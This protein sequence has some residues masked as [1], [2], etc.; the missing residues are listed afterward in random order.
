[1][2]APPQWILLAF[3]AGFASND[4]LRLAQNRLAGWR[5]DR[6]LRRSRERFAAC[7][8]Q[9]VQRINVGS[10]EYPVWN[11]KCADCCAL[12]VDTFVARPDDPM[13]AQPHH[14]TPNIGRPTPGVVIERR[15][16]RPPEWPPGVSR[17][18]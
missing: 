16:P 12:Y 17:S 10:D 6:L 4:L 5:L 8:H 3:G 11:D 7:S 1:M 9:R 18:G 2:I 15:A 14:W 13:P